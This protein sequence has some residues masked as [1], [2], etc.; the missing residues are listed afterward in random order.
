VGQIIKNWLNMEENKY[1]VVDSSIFMCYL[2]PDEVLKGKYVEYFDDFDK[3]KIVFLCSNMV[4]YEVMNSLV[5]AWRQKR[6]KKDMVILLYDNFLNFPIS[7]DDVE[8]DKILALAIKH[9][10]SVYD[11]CYL[12]L[13]K[14]YDCNLLTLDKKLKQAWRSEVKGINC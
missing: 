10:L 11:A 2:L 7:I 5:S 3:R 13:T 4:K 14:K 9:N 12:G 1:L 6:I 8:Y